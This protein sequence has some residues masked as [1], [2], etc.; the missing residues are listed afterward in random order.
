[1][2]ANCNTTAHYKYR[3]LHTKEHN[4][5]T[6]EMSEATTE[7]AGNS[8]DRKRKEISGSE[9][10]PGN[11]FSSFSCPYL[12]TI[13][14]SMLDFDFEPSCSV[15]L[16]SGPHIYGCLVCGKFFRGRGSQTPAYT[17]SVQDGHFVFVHLASTKFYCLPDNYEIQGD[18]AA[19]LSD[20]AAS[21]HPT[22]SPEQI[23]K[24]DEN[25]QLARDLFG[26]RYLPGF[27]GL[28]NLNKTDG[29]NACVQALAHVPPLRDYFLQQAHSDTASSLVADLQPP[30]PSA[31]SSS[32]S[33]TSH[34]VAAH[35]MAQHVTQCFGELVRKLWSDKR[36]KNHIDP[37]M[38]TQAIAVASKNR[39]RIGQQMEAGEFM[40]WF[41][42]QLHRG[43]GGTRQA[44]SSIVHKIFQGTVSVT[45]R[46]LRKSTDGDHGDKEEDDR[47][48]SDDE[49]ETENSNND[50]METQPLDSTM[51]D[52]ADA[53]QPV[54]EE[55][56][57]DSHFLQLTLDMSEKPLF[58]DAD[59]G[60]VI[61]QEPLVT[62]LKKFDGVSFS[63]VVNKAGIAQRRRYRIRKLPPYLILHLA[64]FQTNQFLKVKNPTIVAF[65][66]RNLDLSDYVFSNDTKDN[67][68]TG[69]GE[70]KKLKAPTEEE[71]RAMSVSDTGTGENIA[72]VIHVCLL[73]S[74]PNAT[75]FP[76]RY[77]C[78]L[79]YL[80]TQCT[81]FIRSKISRRY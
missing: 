30:K 13:Q 17:H 49:N 14:R 22:Y 71:V 25:Q 2:K 70:E 66:V 27:V 37:H 7:V 68:S 53:E 16:Q 74:H 1:M 24:I 42:H 35:R 4:R 33:T 11:D 28:N 20:I 62:V 61:P 79:H 60:L 38:L 50:P 5:T 23:A 69:G 41:L 72:A 76:P 47:G 73:C 77:S 44:G 43:L 64:R 52:T 67:G 12:D 46:Q 6:T 58:R 55:T 80:S 56:V 51:N 34:I 81:L 75:T 48:G 8:S 3:I 9:A 36:F 40:A 10:Q 54:V 78:S 21:L 32:T 19:S 59:G 18:D 57:T 29:I 63:D 39:F 65:P 15:S 45:T 31:S 26:R